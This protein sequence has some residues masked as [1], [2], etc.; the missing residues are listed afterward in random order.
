[1]SEELLFRVEGSS[2]LPATP[3][4]LEE[5]GLRERDH[6]QEW[7]MAHPELIGD[8]VKVVTFEFARW[9][10]RDGRQADRLDVLGLD[11]DGT[12]VVIELKRDKAPDTVEMQAIKYA[13]MASRFTPELLAEAHARYLTQQGS[14]ATEEQALEDLTDHAPDLSTETLLTPRIVLMARDFPTDVTATCVWLTEM[15]LDIQLVTFQAYESAG[16]TLVTV[17]RLFPVQDIEDFTISPRQAEVKRATES[18]KRTQAMSAVKRLIEAEEIDDGDE[19]TLEGDLH[20]NDEL[21]PLIEAWL[22]EDPK[23]S[24]ATWVNESSRPLIWAADGQQYSP[25]GLAKHIFKQATGQERAIQGTLWWVDGEGQNIAQLASSVQ[26]GK[27]ALYEEFWSNFLQKFAERDPDLGT[28]VPLSRHY[29]GFKSTVPGARLVFRFSRE[30]KIGAELYIDTGD[31]AESKALFDNLY[32]NRD[33][34]ERRVGEDLVW[35]QLDTRRACRIFLT[36]EGAV[37]DRDQWD[38]YIDWMITSGLKLRDA[39]TP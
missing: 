5:A 33:E 28:R 19:F 25:S 30:S 26:S 10:G 24:Q 4:T 37:S 14:E 2:A 35:E 3:V 38:T 16:Q 32:V 1:V 17:S 22:A 31:P 34:F 21:R 11:S 20:V 27:K 7:V 9:T 13:A 39:F 29:M 18:R 15:G 36:R 6:L 23:R 8:G 12:L